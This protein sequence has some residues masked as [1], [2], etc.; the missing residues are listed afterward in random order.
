MDEKS[1]ELLQ[2]ILIQQ[3]EQTELLRKHLG[4]IRFSLYG[5]MLLVTIS[6]V[7]LGCGMYLLRHTGRPFV[8]P[9]NPP[10]PIPNSPYQN[11]QTPPNRPIPAP[12][13]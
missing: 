5:L 2:E 4:R 7:A 12:I 13:G 8:V 1:V 3:K 10:T 6:G 9:A 11:Y